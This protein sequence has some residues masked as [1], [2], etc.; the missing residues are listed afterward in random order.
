MK[1]SWGDDI[2]N[3][4]KNNPNFPNHQ[5]A[6]LSYH[7]AMQLATKNRPF[8]V[9]VPIQISILRGNCQMPCLISQTWGWHRGYKRFTGMHI[10][11]SK[12]LSA[13]CMAASAR[14]T[15]GPSSTVPESKCRKCNLR[16][17]SPSMD[18]NG[19]KGLF[20]LVTLRQQ[21]YG[22]W[23]SCSSM[24]YHEKRPIF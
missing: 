12:K 2:P 1:V 10:Q 5:P 14:A 21:S 19:S 17:S 24:I 6:Y 18:F 22:K 11:Y 8:L 3:I 20:L 15:S 9:D 7:P 13:C 4:W 23:Y 16:M